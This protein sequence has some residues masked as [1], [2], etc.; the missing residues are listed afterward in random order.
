MPHGRLNKLPEWQSAGVTEALDSVPAEEV[1]LA[2]PRE[3]GS[4]RRT[5]RETNVRTRYETAR[6]ES[7]RIVIRT[8]FTAGRGLA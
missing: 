8:Q 2:R 1:R 7:R 3:A 4:S 6:H 5:A